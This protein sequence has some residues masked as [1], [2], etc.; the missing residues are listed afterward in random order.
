MNW[1]ALYG[2]MR[3]QLIPFP[4]INP[5]KPSSRHILTRLLQT[6]RYCFSPP[7]VGCTCLFGRKIG[8]TTHQTSGLGLN[9]K[10]KDRLYNFDAL[11][12]ADNRPTGRTSDATGN[13]IGRNLRAKDRRRESSLLGLLRSGCSRCD[14]RSLLRWLRGRDASCGCGGHSWRLEGRNSA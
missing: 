5:T 3:K 12:G 1:T 13:K 7:E 14:Q 6:P 11:Q 10:E 8:Q 4:L 9:P 2:T